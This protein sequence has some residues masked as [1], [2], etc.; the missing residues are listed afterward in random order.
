MVDFFLVLVLFRL[1]TNGSGLL[2]CCKAVCI[3]FCLRQASKVHKKMLLA[4]GKHPIL[5]IAMFLLLVVFLLQRYI[6][7]N[8]KTCSSNDL[9]TA[10][11]LQGGKPKRKVKE[12]N[13]RT[14]PKPTK[15]KAKPKP[16]AKTGPKTKSNKSKAAP[17]HRLSRLSGC[18]RL[19]CAGSR[20]NSVPLGP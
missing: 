4:F 20:C 5:L 18:R 15:P 12:P 9:L 10:G 17:T 7:L 13:Q 16:K 2:M 14:K 19:G 6:S 3:V 8:R 1:G 11:A